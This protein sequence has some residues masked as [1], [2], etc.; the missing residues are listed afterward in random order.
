MI[1]KI[2][3]FVASFAI[4]ASAEPA[5]TQQAG[6]V[7]RIGYLSVRSPEQEKGY[8]PAFQQGLRK[9]GYVEGENIVIEARY[10]NRNN[11]R[12]PAL[13]AELLRR[14]VEIVVIGGGGAALAVQR[15]S[16]TIPI[17]MAEATAPSSSA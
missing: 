9:L 4:L 16:K 14:K 1:W 17:V 15:L 2:A 3:V 8:F 13:A 12:L 11:D 10:A 6:K 5:Y 7:Y